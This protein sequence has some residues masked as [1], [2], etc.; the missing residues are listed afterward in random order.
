MGRE[1][2]V[3]SQVE[4]YQ[5]LKKWYLMPLCL[6]LNIIRYRSR[7]KLSN[8]R[9]GVAPSP[10]PW[11]SSYRKGKLGV[12]FEYFIYFT[13]YVLPLSSAKGLY[14]WKWKPNYLIALHYGDTSNNYLHVAGMVRMRRTNLFISVWVWFSSCCRIISVTSWMLET[15]FAKSC[16]I[17]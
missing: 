1:T 4:S 2:W 17:N 6:T 7:V 3:Q 11:C 16:S 8:P 10:T 12:T 5:R 13:Y 15:C 14:A 9:K